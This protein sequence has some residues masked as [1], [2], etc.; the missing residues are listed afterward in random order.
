MQFT[1]PLSKTLL[2]FSKFHLIYSSKSWDYVR[3]SRCKPTLCL[4]LIVAGSLF[5]RILLFSV[6]QIFIHQLHNCAECDVLK[7]LSYFFSSADAPANGTNFV[8]KSKG[9]AWLTAYSL[10]LREL[11][12]FCFVFFFNVWYLL[13][14]SPFRFVLIASTCMCLNIVTSL[15]LLVWLFFANIQ[16]SLG[17]SQHLASLDVMARVSSS[18]QPRSGC[19]S[20]PVTERFEG[21]AVAV[22]AEDP[23]PSRR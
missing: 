2:A 14:F 21:G 23:D 20:P 13:P 1:C 6:F 18:S 10:S 4:C 17:H 11:E 8:H 22:V 7:W 19:A 3:R 5:S 15:C 12:S 16:N 9:K